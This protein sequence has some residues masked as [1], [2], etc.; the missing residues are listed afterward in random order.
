MLGVDV[1]SKTLHFDKGRV[2]V[3]SQLGPL[4]DENVILY[5]W[6]PFIITFG[7]VNEYVSCLFEEDEVL[8]FRG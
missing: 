3:V 7:V 5:I 1:R 8:A 6:S 4:V 2:K